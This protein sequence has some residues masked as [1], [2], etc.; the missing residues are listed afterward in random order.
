MTGR[1]TLSGSV[2]DREDLPYLIQK[3]AVPETLFARAQEF[4]RN[5][6]AWDG[7]ALSALF[8]LGVGHL[9]GTTSRT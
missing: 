7:W 5:G 9:T 8:A 1:E 6:P 2:L 4:F 3:G